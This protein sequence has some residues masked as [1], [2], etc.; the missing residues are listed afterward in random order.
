MISRSVLVGVLIAVLA[1]CDAAAQKFPVAENAFE[2]QTGRTWP[3]L[4]E[5]GIPLY[6]DL[7]AFMMGE[8]PAIMPDS[9]VYWFV[10]FASQKDVKTILAW[11]AEHAE[12]WAVDEDL[13]MLLPEGAEAMDAI[14]G[15]AAFVNLIDSET[16]GGCWTGVP[17]KTMVQIAYKPDSGSDDDGMAQP[18]RGSGEP[19][20]SGRDVSAQSVRVVDGTVENPEGL[21]WPTVEEVG[22]PLYPDLEAFMIGQSPTTDSEVYFFVNFASQADP[23]TVL[24]WYAEHA[25]GWELDA[26]AE[27]LLPD[28]ADVMDA[29][30][31][32]TGFAVVNEMGGSCWDGVPC[33][34]MVQI[35]YRSGS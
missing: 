6:P 12:G 9:E 33:E 16:A 32:K 24:A 30:T 19:T 22:L 4:V 34:T 35:V 31:G 14:M 17:C 23:M 13:G 18:A 25:D 5:I 26:D 2:D 1:G 11:Y 27:M 21:E 7:E 8:N 28:G 29:R 20:P 3:T 10:N 15:K